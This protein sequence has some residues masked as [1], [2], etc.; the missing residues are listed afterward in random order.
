[1]P[2]TAS[3]TSSPNFAASA[4]LPARAPFF[5]ADEVGELAGIARAEH[6]LV[7]VLEETAGQRLRDVA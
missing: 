1:M 7:A 3:T 2:L 5:L 6:H 4:K